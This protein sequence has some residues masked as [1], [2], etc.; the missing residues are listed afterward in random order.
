[1]ASITAASSK[2]SDPSIDGHETDEHPVAHHLGLEPGRAVGIPHCFS[3][4]RQSDADP[5]LVHAFLGRTGVDAA[6]AQGVNDSAGSVLVHR[7]Q[8]TDAMLGTSYV[9]ARQI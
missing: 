4:T 5:E 2:S 3:P 7:N 6:L 1:M 9:A 8:F